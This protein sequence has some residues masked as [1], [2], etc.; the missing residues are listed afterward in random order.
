MAVICFTSAHID[1]VTAPEID[2][3]WSTTFVTEK[4]IFPFFNIAKSIVAQK[5]FFFG[6]DTA[7]RQAAGS[8]P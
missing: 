7:C 2:K 1:T 4:P 6:K 5:Y 8:S 3:R